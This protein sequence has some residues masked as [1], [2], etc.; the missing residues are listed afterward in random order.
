M[1]LCPLLHSSLSH[2]TNCIPNFYSRIS[3]SSLSCPWHSG[4]LKGMTQVQSLNS[5]PARLCVYLPANTKALVRWAFWSRLTAGRLIWV[6]ASVQHHLLTMCA[7]VWKASSTI[8]PSWS[9]AAWWKTAKMFFQ[10]ERMFPAWEFTI[11]AMQR[12]T[13]SRIVGDLKGKSR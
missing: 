13:M 9:D 5:L 11:W 4:H 1:I 10:P 8:F 6:H 3:V 7:V 12:I 2:P